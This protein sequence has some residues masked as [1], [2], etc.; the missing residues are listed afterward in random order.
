MLS[1][2]KSQ[3][4]GGGAQ[5]F[6]AVMTLAVLTSAM[7][8]VAGSQWVKS[9]TGTSDHMTNIYRVGCEHL[10]E[11]QEGQHALE[12]QLDRMRHLARRMEWG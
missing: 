5:A 12:I 9:P 4:P 3:R 1:M 7:L 2:G 10:L 11:L 8:N 6:L